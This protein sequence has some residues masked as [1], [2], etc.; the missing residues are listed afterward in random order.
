MQTMQAVQL[1]KTIGTLMWF[2]HVLKV[3]RL[4]SPMDEL[5]HYPVPQQEIEEFKDF[6]SLPLV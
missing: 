4:T 3:N 5:L 6:V 1:N 2:Y